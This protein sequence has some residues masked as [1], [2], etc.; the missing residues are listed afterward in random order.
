MELDLYQLLK[1]KHKLNFKLV[2]NRYQNLIHLPKDFI[3]KTLLDMYL[4]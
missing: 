4:S 1:H 3:F 2:P